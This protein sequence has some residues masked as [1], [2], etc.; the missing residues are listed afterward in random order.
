[1]SGIHMNK[2]QLKDFKNATK[3]IASDKPTEVPSK[4][5]KVPSTEVLKQK[6]KLVRR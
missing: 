3:Q 6:W 4:P 5:E 1:M 2:R